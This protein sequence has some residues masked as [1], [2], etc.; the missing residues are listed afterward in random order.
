M[1]DMLEELLG[2]KLRYTRLPWRLSDQRF[3][4]ADHAKA[5]RLLGWSPAV[6]K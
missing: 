1:F 5:T 3:F 2:V 6:S 4:V